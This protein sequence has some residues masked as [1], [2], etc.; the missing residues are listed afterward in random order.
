MADYKLINKSVWLEKEKILII[1][2]LHIGYEEY[3]EQSGVFL[4][5][6]QYEQ[7]ISELEGI[8][9]QILKKQ[10]GEKKRNESKI[11]KRIEKV[12]ILGDLKHEFGIISNQEWQDVLN[13]LDYL[14]EKTKKIILIKG[15]HDKILKPIAEKRNV[16]VK[17]F[18]IENEKAFI[19]G[20]RQF[21]EVLDKKIEK[22]FVGH[23][24]PAITFTRKAKKE[25]YKCYLIGKY[26]KKEII[27]LPSFFPLTE[28]SDV[29]IEETN[30]AYKFNLNNFYVFI[31][32]IEENKILGF[33]K[34]KESGDLV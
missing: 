6:T 30:L 21:L 16:E 27:I 7:I 20:D 2:D 25:T 10:A 29:F 34:V 28:G 18:H 19:H 12:I 31:P 26:K 14:L 32:I 22:I 5:R 24:H 8:F 17:D 1:T 15:N 33:G 11:N 23:L 3:L 9:N 4:P 13:F